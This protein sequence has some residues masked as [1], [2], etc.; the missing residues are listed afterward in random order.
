MNITRGDTKSFKFQRKSDG[1]PITTI[2]DKIYFTVKETNYT[3]D[4]IFQKTI[5]DMTFDEEYYYHFTILPED[6][7]DLEYGDYKYDIEVKIGDTYVKTISKG[8]F[9]IEDETTHATNEV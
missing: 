7:N 9:K 5:D 2:A 6:T 8:I 3:N 1:Q 4:M